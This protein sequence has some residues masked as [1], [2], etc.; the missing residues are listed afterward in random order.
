MMMMHHMSMS[1]DAVGDGHEI[2]LPTA[3]EKTNY[4]RKY[5]IKFG[6]NDRGCYIACCLAGLAFFFFVIIVVMAI[7]WPGE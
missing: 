4:L 2:K 3:K 5:T 6:L 7:C 1:A